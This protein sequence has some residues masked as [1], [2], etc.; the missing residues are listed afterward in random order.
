[1]SAHSPATAA[2]SPDRR[3]RDV[4]SICDQAIAVGLD[5]SGAW[6][7]SE[8]GLAV[9]NT[10]GIW[11]YDLRTHASLK[12]V[13]M[14]ESSSGYAERTAVD[15]ATIDAEAVGREAVAKAIQGRDPVPVAAGTYT[16]VLEPYAVGTMI[17]YLAY[18]GL[19]AQ[20]L[21]EGRSFMSGRLGSRVTGENISLWDDALDPSGM[22]AAFD[23][24]GVPKQRVMLIDRGVAS[25]VVYDS[26]TA[27]RGERHSTG[28]ALP[29]PNTFGPLPL[30]LFLATGDGDRAGLLRGITHGLWVTRF[31]YVNVV[32][33]TRTVL[34]GMT[35]DGTFLIE[36]GEISRAVH[37]LRFTQSVLDALSTVEAIGRESLLLQD[38]LGGTRVP[39]LRI[40]EFSFSSA[41]SFG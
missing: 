33:P 9:A 8:V 40:G 31:H 30:N 20:A 3:A 2:Y 35:R 7:T 17:D 23:F 36:N 12:T 29:A 25:D 41:T 18:M 22:P 13:I 21:Q 5:A 27:A 1:V 38:D 6:S 19:G 37:N 11:A 16:V 15:A 28:H 14:G 26:Y 34:T 39:P 24:E 4:K 10:R 32:H